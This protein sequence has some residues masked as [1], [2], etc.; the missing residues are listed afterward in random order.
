MCEIMVVPTL[1]QQLW[2]LV[3]LGLATGVLPLLVFAAVW[4][5]GEWLNKRRQ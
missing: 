2:E 3:E 1:G 5:V 4:N